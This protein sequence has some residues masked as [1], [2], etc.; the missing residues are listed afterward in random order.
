MV[1]FET[2]RLI[3]RSFEAS[4]AEGLFDYFHKPTVNCFQSEKLNTL[5]D[6]KAEVIKRRAQASQMAIC[7]KEDKQLIGNLFA[8]KESDTFA[9]N[10]EDTYGVGWNLNP[11]FGGHGYATEAAQGLFHYLFTTKGVRRVYCY[12]EEDNIPSQKLC[13]RLGMRQEGMFLD[14]VSFVKNPDGTARYE[15][16]MQFAILKR[17]WKGA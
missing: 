3:V 6:A 5:D 16:T 14:Y 10:E 11:K 2:A 8:E 1:F 9:E 7:L 4:D 17:E 15:N 13:K 12:V